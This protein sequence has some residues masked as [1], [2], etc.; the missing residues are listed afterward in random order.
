M[1][2]AG[3]ANR[4]GASVSVSGGPSSYTITVDGL[5][6]TGTV[7]A[8]LAA[9]VVTDMAR[10]ANTASTSTD[11]TVTVNLDSTPPVITPNVVGT[12]G[13]N[14]WYV[15]NVTVSWAVT[16]PESTIT[17]QSGCDPASVNTDIGGV[18][19]TCSATSGGGS[20]SQSVTVKRDATAP[21]LAV[22]ANQDGRRDHP[23]GC[24]RH[25]WACHLR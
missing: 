25:L 8:S 23:R 14:G 15:S 18:T 11:N 1:T 4:A 5:A 17:S 16:D 19:F 12:L 6:G 9:N 10:N 2:L 22:P 3:T 20:N 21:A 13:N 7:I 24:N